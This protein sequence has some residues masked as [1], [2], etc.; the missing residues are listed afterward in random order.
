[1]TAT[2][3][4]VGMEAVTRPRVIPRAVHPPEPCATKRSLGDP[5]NGWDHVIPISGNKTRIH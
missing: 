1:M 2:V 5:H 3:L 4:M